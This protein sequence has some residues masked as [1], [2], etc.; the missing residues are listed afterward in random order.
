MKAQITEVKKVG[1]HFDWDISALLVSEHG[2]YVISTGEHTELMFKGTCI[3]SDDVSEIG[4]VSYTWHKNH[5]KLV[6]EQITIK[7]S[8]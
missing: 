3:Y 4:H 6:K 1:H 7:L 8:N 2:K 5:F